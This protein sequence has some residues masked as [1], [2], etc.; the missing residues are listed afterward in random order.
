M[1]APRVL[2]PY[3]REAVNSVLSEW[4]TNIRRTAVVLPTGTGK[5]TVIAEIAAES[6]RRGL[7]VALLAHRGELLDQ[8][9]DTVTDV[10]PALPRPGIVR[11]D[12]DDSDAQIVAAMFQTVTSDSR[13]ARLGKRDV[14]LCDECFVAGTLVDGRPIESL[15]TGDTVTSWSESGDF[16]RR[17]VVRTM[18]S[19]PSALVRVST[20]DWQHFIC[21]PRHPFLTPMGW[22]PAG[23]LSRGVQLHHVN[24]V[25]TVSHIRGYHHEVPA[26]QNADTGLDI[27]LEDVLNGVPRGYQF[28][29]NGGDEP[30]VRL[31]A[32]AST[33]SHAQPGHASEGIEHF[34]ANRTSTRSPWGERNQPDSSAIASGFRSDMGYGSSDRD[35]G[36]SAPVQVLRG[37]R[38]SHAENSR[39][40]RR[41]ESQRAE[42]AHIGRPENRPAR[43]PRV[44][45]VAVLEPG[46]DGRYGGLCPDGL[47]YNIEV[48]HDHTYTVGSGVVVHNCHHVT[49]PSY[50]KV[51]EGF[52]P[53]T[54]FCGFTAT[55]R[56]ED[57]K[58]LRTMIDSVAFERSLRW[59]VDEA[60]LVRPTGITVK[61][62]EL[63]LGKVKTTA[64]DFQQNALAEVMEAE[65]PEIVKA[66]LKHCR[67]R[68][69]IIFAASVAAAHDIAALLNEQGMS[70]EA[71]T[72][73]M[74]YTDR[75][76]IYDRF[77][78]GETRAMV[79]VMVLTEG[80][81]FPMCDA[82]VIA[83][84][85][86]SQILY[87]QMV[88]RSL[89]PWEDK[90]DALVLDLVG[91]SRVLKLVTLISLDAG[92]VS[93][94]VDTD[95]EDLPPEDDEEDW[96]NPADAGVTAVPKNRRLGPIDTIGIDL[97]GPAETGVLWLGTVKG[98]PF[99][100]PP[101][102]AL[103][104]FLWEA[105]YDAH[106]ALYKVGYMTVKGEKQGGWL[107]QGQMFPLTIA[108]DLAEDEIIDSGFSFP[109]R[110][111]SW[112]RS[113]PPSDAQLR[114]ARVLGILEAEN[115]SKARLSDEISIAL[116]SARL[117]GA[118]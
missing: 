10:D 88:G 22:V 54:F 82:V 117:D 65:T 99:L 25:Q 113:A 63:D 91:T 2:R 92:T 39:G 90:E 116:M 62:P 100:I 37:Y 80:A 89:R 29:D 57:G 70:A 12:Q 110:A 60:Y 94:V 47:V 55:L 36:W 84:P 49:A 112:R 83:R 66:V 4:G 72:G 27:L 104:W 108:K 77:R 6:V 79:T 5:S 9:A 11:A 48:E 56:R 32:H 13:H 64:G 111:A 52:G 31:F 45:S 98:V 93:R 43:A 78:S 86:Q 74:D 114:F 87:S 85:T 20:D 34:T 24:A 17:R 16:V 106:G 28:T 15:R 23:E 18:T 7:R 68:R 42:T 26:G 35:D 19:V 115:M 44:D 103:A 3:Q 107:A 97:L 96:L 81:D 73:A 101:E 53:D 1:T 30:Q 51:V 40:S 14:V 41:I 21:T 33:Q 58:A 8:M 109:L 61:I 105:G 69:P 46:S 71:V 76:P 38:K 75:K 102:S 59:A 95:G 67:D 118:R 50:R